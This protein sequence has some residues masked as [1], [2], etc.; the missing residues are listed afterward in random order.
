MRRKYNFKMQT[1]RS[2]VCLI[3][4][5]FAPV[6]LGA[7][8]LKCGANSADLQTNWNFAISFHNNVGRDLIAI[9][10]KETSEAGSR[11]VR[12]DLHKQVLMY[13]NSISK[14]NLKLKENEKFKYHIQVEQEETV[15]GRRHYGTL[16]IQ[17]LETGQ[18]QVRKAICAFAI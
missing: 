18:A 13:S 2:L 4:L 10:L 17:N 15:A 11:V 16:Q 12:F 3:S 9:K 6:I 8:T 5:F 14:L 1:M 7:A